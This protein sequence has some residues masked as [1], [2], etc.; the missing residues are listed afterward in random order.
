MQEWIHNESLQMPQ[1]KELYAAQ[2]TAA[3]TVWL[4]NECTIKKKLVMDQIQ[5]R[6]YGHRL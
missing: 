3:L 4:K 5:S 6:K 2:A 1:K